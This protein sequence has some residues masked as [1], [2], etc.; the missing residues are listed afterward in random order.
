MPS[1]FAVVA[2]WALFVFCVLYLGFEGCV[3][4]GV[5]LVCHQVSTVIYIASIPVVDVVASNFIL[6]AK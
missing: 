2:V 1:S 6:F 3:G 5:R 4:I